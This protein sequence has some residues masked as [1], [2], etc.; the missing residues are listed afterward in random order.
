MIP[1]EALVEADL[2]LHS[3]I[4]STMNKQRRREVN[5]RIFDERHGTELAP[6]NSN[7]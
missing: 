2:V 7:E 4:V 6:L 3:P 1:Q 5:E